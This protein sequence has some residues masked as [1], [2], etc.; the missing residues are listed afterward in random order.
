MNAKDDEPIVIANYDASWPTIFEQEKALL[1]A[2][3]G[4]AAI[5]ID[6]I[7]STA[8]PGLSAK[9]VIDIQIGVKEVQPDTEYA[10]KLAVLGYQSKPDAFDNQHLFFYKTSKDGRRTH[11]VHIVE[12]GTNEQMRHIVFRDYLRS[13][14]RGATEYEALKRAM[15][16]KFTNDRSAYVDAKTAFITLALCMYGST[17]G[18]PQDQ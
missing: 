4:D 18:Q 3:L 17:S 14:P 9:P 16:E 6:H 5:S 7:G 2:S 15:A 13:N 1:K 12:E 11:H 10:E 8:V